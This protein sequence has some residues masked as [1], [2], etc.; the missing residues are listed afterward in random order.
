MFIAVCEGHTEK[1]LTKERNSETTRKQ[2]TNTNKTK[3]KV[4]L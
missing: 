3:T 4:Q 2:K 1:Y